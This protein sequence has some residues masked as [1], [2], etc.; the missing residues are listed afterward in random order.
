MEKKLLQRAK[1]IRVKCVDCCC[2]SYK[3]V[4]LCPVLDC[5]L[6]PW[7]FGRPLTKE[8]TKLWE[9]DIPVPE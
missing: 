5:S 8:E 1:A 6:Y 2:G 9:Q 7:R 4:K 3:E